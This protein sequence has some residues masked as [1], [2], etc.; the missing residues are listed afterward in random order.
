MDLYQEDYNDGY[1]H[2]GADLEEYPNNIIYDIWSRRGPGKTY[3]LLRYCLRKDMILMYVKRTNKDVD[4]ITSYEGPAEKDPSPYMPI[5]RDF[6][7]NIRPHHQANGFA[8]FKDEDT[9]KIVAF[10]A[11]LNS[12]KILKGMDLSETDLMAMDE[13]I[14]L[15]GEV[16]KKDEGKMLLSLY[17]TIKRDRVKRGR[18]HLKL[19]LLANADE[20][21]T[22]ITNTLEIVDAM[23]DMNMLKQH[24]YEW[25]RRKIFLRHISMEDYPLAAEELDDMYTVMQGTEWAEANYEGTFAYNDFTNIKQMSIKSMRCMYYLRYRKTQEAYI[26]L[27]PSDGMYYMCKTKGRP[28]QKYDLSRE[29]E[30]KRFWLEHGI[31]LRAACIDER[32]K[33]EKYSMYDLIVNYTHMYDLH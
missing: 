8:V 27:R 15:P 11:S 7:K 25:K 1:Y 29:N 23:A 2:V 20:I 32:F 9:G 24:V 30:Q 17:E 14:P 21:S 6:G 16:V 28:I 10:L 4:F 26:Y 3:S 31:D 33:F 19:V 5:N 22:P 18:G 13:Y 12:L